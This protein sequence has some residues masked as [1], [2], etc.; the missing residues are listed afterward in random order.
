MLRL[1]AGPTEPGYV[2]AAFFL[3]L[4]GQHHRGQPAVDLHLEYF[5]AT[6]MDFIKIQ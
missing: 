3:H 4:D 2:P 6:E 5:R 1:A